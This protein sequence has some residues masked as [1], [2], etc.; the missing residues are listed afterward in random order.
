MILPGLLVLFAL[1]AL[2][3]G[4]AVVFAMFSAFGGR[5]PAPRALIGGAATLGVLAVAASLVGFRNLEAWEM[6]ALRPEL[7]RIEARAVPLLAAIERFERDHGRPLAS[8]DELTPDYIAA[9]PDTGA[10]PFE[11]RRHAGGFAGL[12]VQ[13]SRRPTRFDSFFYSPQVLPIESGGVTRRFGDWVYY[14]E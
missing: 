11:W 4:L 13:V 7:E 5:V 3:L 2:L 8:L 6:D 12:V 14:V 9:I 10:A 1:G